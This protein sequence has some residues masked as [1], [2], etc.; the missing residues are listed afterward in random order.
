MICQDF[1]L[2]RIKRRI[3]SKKEITGSESR[4]DVPINLH[5]HFFSLEA[6]RVLEKVSMSSRA[7]D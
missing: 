7:N 1:F 3:S 4:L 5:N 2:N 6:L